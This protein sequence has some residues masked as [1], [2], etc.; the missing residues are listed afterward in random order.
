M[1][2]ARWQ[3]RARASSV[4][5]SVW[6]G[7][8]F[9]Q[10]FGQLM[11]TGCEVVGEIGADDLVASTSTST[12]RDTTS[13][14]G[15]TDDATKPTMTSGTASSSESGSGENDT[16][17]LALDLGGEIDTTSEDESSTAYESST[18]PPDEAESSGSSGPGGGVAPCCEAAM[19]PG[20]EDPEIEACVCAA[21]DFCCSDQWDEACV[22]V[23][24]FG[25]CGAVCEDMPIAPP[26]GECCVENEDAGGCLDAGVQDCVC[27]TDPY[28]CA[29]AWDNV[30][31]DYVEQ[32]G[33]GM[34][35]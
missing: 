8:A 28:C 22:D 16:A 12:G 14:H 10:L 20:C 18:F 24:V 3:G 11:G 19:Q 35:G 26:P 6:L 2:N 32:L 34:C 15:T 33:C 23:A 17:T 7:L 5:A 27:A 13:E 1:T 31:V 21:D 25:D 30:C 4:S 29:Y 9:G